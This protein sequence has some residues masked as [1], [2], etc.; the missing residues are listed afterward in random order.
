[1]KTRRGFYLAL[2]VAIIAM[3]PFLEATTRDPASPIVAMLASSFTT[4]FL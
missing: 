4:R 3:Q 1:M 2:A